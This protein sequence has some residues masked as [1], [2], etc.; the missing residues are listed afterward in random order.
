MCQEQ[1][2]RETLI[3][4]SCVVHVP[5]AWYNSQRFHKGVKFWAK[6]C[7]C[8]TLHLKDIKRNLI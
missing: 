8:L 5:V 7:L 4:I 6:F 2:I 1:K 3:L